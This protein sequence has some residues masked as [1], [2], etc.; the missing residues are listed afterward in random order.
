MSFADLIT[1]T[2]SAVR[3]HLGGVSAIYTPEVGDAATV[4]GIFDEQYVMSKPGEAG[5]EQVG[6]ALWVTLA[7]LP[8]DPRTENPTIT[9]AGVIYTVKERP[10]DG[11]GGT[12]R[13]LLKRQGQ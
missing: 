2:D 9:I 7:D 3:A 10:T 4:S 1:S 5:A 8:A 13:L 6:P 12:I 11:F